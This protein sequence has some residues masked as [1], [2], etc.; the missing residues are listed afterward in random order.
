LLWLT[1]VD[2]LPMLVHTPAAA[3]T[4]KI[5]ILLAVA[6]WCPLVCAQC[7][8]NI[9]GYVSKPNTNWV[10]SSK[11]QESQTTPA[12]AQQICSLDPNCV[13]WNNFGY[14]ILASGGTAPT[15]AAAGITFTPY[16]SLCTYV[17][18]TALPSC[19]DKDG[20]ITKA[21]TNWVRTSQTQESQTTPGNAQQICNLDTNCLAWNNFGYYILA[22]GG[23][24]P[25]VAASGISFQPYD[26]MCTYVKASAL[27]TKP[28]SN[29]PGSGTGI[30][31]NTNQLLTFR[32]KAN[33]LCFAANDAERLLLDIH[34]LALEPC[35]AARNTQGFKIVPAGKA[36]V[37][38][39]RK[40]RCIT[41]Y[42]GIFVRTAAVMRCTR[43]DDQL[44]SI[45]SASAN[46]RGPF[47]IKSQENGQCITNSRNLLTLG[48]CSSS[49]A[50]AAFQLAPM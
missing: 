41:T 19:P 35:S 9:A 6:L 27:Q 14:Y 31:S 49:N 4:M 48:A 5:A 34:R 3:I 15:V 44:W 17:K 16:S 8:N 25:T 7:T 2:R 11:T 36:F 20:Y 28:N 22:K 1:I 26:K 38:V 37:I 13:A 39:D 45:S 21:D 33:N 12:N 50:N 32:N 42:D 24:T 18:T 40:G 29:P 47:T 23:T 10:R 30:S 46:G 43:N